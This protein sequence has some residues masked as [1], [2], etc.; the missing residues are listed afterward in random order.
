MARHDEVLRIVEAL[1]AMGGEVTYE[2]AGLIRVEWDSSQ[3]GFC[4]TPVVF[5]VSQ[6]SASLDDV[7]IQIEQA[8]IDLNVLRTNMDT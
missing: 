5:D 3:P 8:G 2:V 1:K 4:P 6:E 7:W